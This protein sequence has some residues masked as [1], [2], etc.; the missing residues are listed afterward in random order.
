MF[1]LHDTWFYWTHRL[2]HL[3]WL[4]HHHRHHHASRSPTPW[5]AY[6]FGPLEAVFQ[7]SFVPLVLFV[8]PL[9]TSIIVL[10]YGGM[11]LR[12]LIGHS[13][14]EVFPPAFLRSPWLSWLTTVTHHDLHHQKGRYN[15]GL[16]TRLWDRWM[17]TEDPDYPEEYAQVIARAPTV[18]EPDAEARSGDL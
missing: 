1:L 14:F 16:Y 3:P 17:G 15:F 11:L 10:F 6:T 5:T 4:A 7:S 13:G 18:P 2:L 9:H 12:N 8:L